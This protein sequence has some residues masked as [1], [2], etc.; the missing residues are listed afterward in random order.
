MLALVHFKS[1]L[2][3]NAVA[4]LR[5]T[6][7]Y[8]C[9]EPEAFGGRYCRLVEDVVGRFHDLDIDHV[10]EFS[11]VEL[12]DDVRQ[13]ILERRAVGEIKKKARG[14]GMRTLREGAIDKV[15]DGTTSL[16]EINKVTFVE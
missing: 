16:R 1:E 5:L 3:A 8:L 14:F 13:L 15:F 12:H 4:R 2:V 6:I 11:D 7:D 9:L 10:A